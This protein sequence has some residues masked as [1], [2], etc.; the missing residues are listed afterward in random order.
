MIDKIEQVKVLLEEINLQ[1]VAE[2]A[3]FQAKINELSA[4]QE[5]VTAERDALLDEKATIVA[6]IR[7][8]LTDLTTRVAAWEASL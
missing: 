8:I 5:A 7:G 3:A 4:S 6:E 1:D 2:D